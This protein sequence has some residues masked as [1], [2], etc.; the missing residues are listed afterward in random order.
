MPTVQLQSRR[1]P[2]T[3]LVVLGIVICIHWT[4][5]SR[6]RLL[7]A[8]RLGRHLCAA[9]LLIVVAIPRVKAWKAEVTAGA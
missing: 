7:L 2:E 5:P 1:V 9:E 4:Q 8:T 6:A 3:E